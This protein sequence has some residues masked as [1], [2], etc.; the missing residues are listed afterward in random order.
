MF[1]ERS[2]GV[3]EG[4]LKSIYVKDFKSNGSSY[5]FR[6]DGG[7]SLEDFQDRVGEAIDNVISAQLEGIEHFSEAKALAKLDYTD[8]YEEKELKLSK[9]QIFEGFY[10]DVE[11][12]RVLIV[13]HSGFIKNAIKYL[14]R[15]DESDGITLEVLANT[16]LT[17]F[18]VF[19]SRCGGLC[20]KKGKRCKY[21]AKM[22]LANDTSHLEGLDEYKKEL[23]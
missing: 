15:L 21:V 14:S 4:Q 3:Y 8:L 20:F 16:S 10:A 22:L 1:R 17:V 18:K 7:E 5:K 6:P 12:P 13:T 11:F 9:K 19:C 2:F 23:V